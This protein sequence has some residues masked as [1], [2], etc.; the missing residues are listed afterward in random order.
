MIDLSGTATTCDNLP[1]FPVDTDWRTVTFYQDTILSC[2]GG[3]EEQP[4]ENLKCHS[5]DA[6]SGTW[7]HVATLPDEFTSGRQSSVI[8]GKVFISGGSTGGSDLRW[9]DTWVWNGVSLTSGPPLAIDSFML[10][11][12][13]VALNETHVFEAETDNFFGG[14]ANGETFLLEWETGQWTP[15]APMPA[16]YTI[17]ATRCAKVQSVQRGTEIV[18]VGYDAGLGTGGV[19]MVYNVDSDAW[20]TGPSYEQSSFDKIAVAQLRYTFVAFSDAKGLRYDPAA[21]SFEQL[22][23]MLSEN[24][25]NPSVVAVPDE[26]VNCN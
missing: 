19:S 10:T 1:A 22:P 13:Q 8:G 11:H 6:A 14:G 20:R 24:T 4:S 18:V 25:Q 12:C 16:T 3:A 17:V 26:F 7:I 15:L 9:L 21:D 5:Y 2:A 23:Q